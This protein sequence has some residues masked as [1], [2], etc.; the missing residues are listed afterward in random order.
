MFTNV[1]WNSYLIAI[2]TVCLLWYLYIG[3]KYY[4]EEI[5]GLFK[6]GRQSN[7]EIPQQDQNFFIS[8]PAAPLEDQ[9]FEDATY[10]DVEDL[11]GRIVGFFDGLTGKSPEKGQAEQYLSQLLAEYPKLKNSA[12]RAQLNEAIESASLKS[13][14]SCTLTINE[15]DRLW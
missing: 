2:G 6:K 3:I 8:E 4:S 15:A 13:G 11:N 5:A 9:G 12:F 14:T 1:T 7:V 10:R